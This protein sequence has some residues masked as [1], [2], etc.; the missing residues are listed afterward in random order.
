MTYTVGYEKTDINPWVEFD[1]GNG[2]IIGIPAQYTNSNGELVDYTDVADPANA[3]TI[4]ETPLYDPEKGEST[5]KLLTVSMG[6][7]SGSAN[8]LSQFMSDDN[9]D[10]II[11]YGDGLFA[12]CT[13]VTDSDGT[14]V[15]YV[16]LDALTAQV[17]L[18][19]DIRKYVTAAMQAAGVTVLENNIMVSANHSHSAVSF[20]TGRSKSKGTAL[21]AYYDYMIQRI[22]NAAVAAYQN[23]SQAT[24]SK[25]EIRAPQTME[26][27]GYGENV[28]LNF[29]RDYISLN[30]LESS[31]TGNSNWKVEGT[32]VVV[33][34]SQSGGTI[35]GRWNGDK[36]YRVAHAKLQYISHLSDVDNTLYVLQFER[37]D[38]DPVLMINWRAHSTLNGHSTFTNISGDYANALRYRLE[39]NTS[40]GGDQDYCVAFWNGAAG[41]VNPSGGLEG[42]SAWKT[43]PEQDTTDEEV[44]VPFVTGLNADN[45]SVTGV[46]SFYTSYYNNFIRDNDFT[47]KQYYCAKYGYLLAKVTL[48]CLENMT[49]CETGK[50]YTMQEELALN[51]NQSVSYGQY[52]AAMQC[53]QD[54]NAGQTITYPYWYERDLD[55]DGVAERYILNSSYHASCARSQYPMIDPDLDGVPLPLEEQ[56]T[57]SVELDVVKLGEQVAM[58]T[59]PFEPFDRYITKDGSNATLATINTGNRWDD[60]VDDTYG[61][62]F[63]LGYSNK[64]IGYLPNALAY[65]YNNDLEGTL[66]ESY[67]GAGS[68]ESNSTK[69]AQGS[70]EKIIDELGR[71]LKTV[72]SGKREAW[73]DACN[74]KVTWEPRTAA[75]VNVDLS[76]G[77]YYLTENALG[78]GSDALN[79]IGESGLY[80]EKV[81]LDLNG[82]TLE[83]YGRVFA[84]ND[85]SAVNIMDSSE[86][87]TGRILAHN[88]GNNPGG[89]LSLVYG[90]GKISLYG[91][92]LEFTNVTKE[93][94]PADVH[95]E[96]LEDHYIG[97][98]AI[99]W[100]Q[101]NGVFNIYGGTV[102]GTQ[103]HVPYQPDSNGVNQAWFANGS[104]GA[105]TISGNGQ[106]NVY[107][108][109][110]EGGKAAQAT[111]LPGGTTVPAG[112]GDCVSIDNIN[113]KVTLAGD[114]KVDEI[115]INVPDG[116]NSTKQA[117][118][119]MVNIEGPFTGSVALN[120]GIAGGVSLGNGFDLGSVSGQA[121]V[122]TGT[123][124]SK[125]GYNLTAWQGNLMGYSTSVKAL[126]GNN[127]YTDLSSAISDYSDTNGFI[128]LMSDAGKLTISEDKTAYIDLNGYGIESVD[129]K[130]NAAVALHVLDTQTD[131]YKIEGTKE[132][133]YTG[134]GKIGSVS[135]VSIAAVTSADACSA[136][137]YLMF[138]E[139]GGYSFHRVN[140][141][142]TAM[143]LRPHNNVDAEGVYNPSVYYKSAF[144]GDELVADNISSY[145]IALS[146]LGVPNQENMGTIGDYS[147]FD[148]FA[149]GADS[150]GASSTVL[151]GVL[152][153]SN[154]NFTNIS[155]AAL[156]IY[157][158]A[159]I[160]LNNGQYVF[161]E[162]VC[163]TFRELLEAANDQWDNFTPSQQEATVQVYRIYRSVMRSWDIPQIV[164]ASVQA[165]NVGTG[166][167]VLD[168]KKIIFIGNSY[169]FYGNTVLDKG[170]RLHQ[171]DRVNDKGFFY[172]LCKSNGIDVNVTN[173]TFGGH[174]ITDT[175]GPR[176]NHERCVERLQTDDPTCGYV[177]HTKYL[178]DA[179]YDYVVI[180]PYSESN[181]YVG[182]LAEHLELVTKFFRKANPNVKFVLFVPHMAAEKNY[183][184]FKDLND[185]IE[186]GFIIANWGE[187]LDDICD[188]KVTVPGATLEFNRNTF[189]VPD[190]HHENILAGYITSLMAYCAITGERPYTSNLD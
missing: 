93:N 63:V 169:T 183:V 6:G 30:T 69:A 55:G 12:T 81:C 107:G 10:G 26:R 153:E 120:L 161:G 109:V 14:T 174:N 15:V 181:A 82:M 160:V 131:D 152:R 61:T 187:M 52:L 118:G 133:G 94:W 57:T 34:T 164:D 141:Q 175:F 167:E 151:Y 32:Q 159:Y 129:T 17:Y 44:K 143:T 110:I 72:E 171:E 56:S 128:R 33:R 148:N 188:G 88:G 99:C 40:F 48:D 53:Q 92:T 97:K 126:M 139:N 83:T 176:C 64:D 66:L 105:F 89:G 112:T 182:D 21:R 101:G 27:L 78:V 142:M 125:Q 62:P 2:E 71:M 60:L 80:T 185:A 115:Y 7:Y 24:M 59:I 70:G 74:A 85:G 135:G 47:N 75:Q 119:T 9:G 100:I 96:C 127:T 134:Y 8:R 31:T 16:T 186:A 184:W 111:T 178:T 11:G 190:N 166:K 140:L 36:Y 108:G 170:H 39:N 103:L 123:I 173:W 137:D 155:Y 163:R 165:S 35:V 132:N 28:N 147:E 117:L 22:A 68:Y 3:T 106:L 177:N 172:Q 49:S 121:T 130:K 104:G 67:Y 87:Q 180:Q 19:A 168:G 25:G 154:S 98:G 18:T 150:N 144:A 102:K 73:C 29:V 145:G 122:F 43:N 158:R 50:I 37:E 149:A 84:V 76:S 86:N 46:N 45:T 114:A 77:H 54:V 124:T 157:G 65:D 138:Q 51:H 116:N 38:A 90:T 156:P 4:V 1:I 91:G 79:N 146:L 136:S 95:M 5:A 41:N 58:V 189:V 113:A 13:T 23:G 179:Y 20:T 42:D 162:S